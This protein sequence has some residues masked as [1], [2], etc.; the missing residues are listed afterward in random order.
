MIKKLIEMNKGQKG[1]VVAI[2]G[3]RGKIL[4]LAEMGI[5]PG[6][7]VI[8]LQKSLGPV[9]IKVKDTNLA[10]GKGLAESILVEVGENGKS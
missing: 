9:I 8:L 7:E 4:R 2:R 1:R 5:T 3:G 10:L 6:E